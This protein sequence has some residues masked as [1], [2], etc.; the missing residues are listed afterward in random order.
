MFSSLE[1]SRAYAL[2]G[3]A[4]FTMDPAQPRV[5]AVGVV[6]GRIVA[7]GSVADVEAA[8]PADAPRIDVGT[9]MVLPGFTDSHIHFGYLV[10]KWNAV[11]LDNCSSLS[12]ALR[13]VKQYVET[14]SKDDAPWIDGH[15]WAAHQWEEQP[16]AA[17]LD[18]VVAD[19]P[20]AL[21]GKDGHSLWVNSA[22]L[23]VAGIER[24]TPNPPGGVIE[25]HPV[26]GE[27]TGVLYEDAMKLVLDV[28]PPMDVDTLAEAMRASLHRLHALGI[29]A[30]HCP[31]LIM[32]WRA[33]Q[34]LWASGELSVR[35]TFMPPAAKLDELVELGVESGFGDRWLRFGQLKFFADGTLGSRTAAMLAPFEGEPDNIGVTVCGGDELKDL[36][37]RA[38][39]A[40]LSVSIHAIGDRGVREALDAIEA[41]D[42]GALRLPHRI[43]H[44][45]LVDPADMARFSR[46]GVVASMQPAHGAVDRANAL[47]YWGARVAYAS[48][49]RSLADR[50]AVLAFGS[51][52]P[53]GL[54]L[55]DTSFSV[56]VGIYTAMTRRW[57]T[58][59]TAD[60]GGDT[61]EPKRHAVERDAYAPDEVVSLDE[62]LAAYTVGPAI[63]G[64]EAGWR[65]SL[66]IG[67]CADFVVLEENL[68]DVPAD[69]IP[70][71]PVAATIVEGKVVYRGRLR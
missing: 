30:I 2:V 65:G 36:V 35:V 29:T 55:T 43:E 66:R 21:T 14:R 8:L 63:V 16:T 52:A 42:S 20:V 9:R 13:R 28:L 44:A 18:A 12:E 59:L 64:G 15:G 45:Q 48:P 4:I 7:V 50:G 3:D 49:Y 58:D 1:L 25:R 67:H 51:D 39:S 5:R 40:G 6:D 31:E 41:A 34:R 11:D 54:D 24:N 56:L 22:A 32:D 37:G 33:Y 17:A 53:F 62:A 69:E 23:A 10:R 19:R 47:K 60:F 70:N 71:V 68:Y 61:G 57:V 26:T 27:P 46:L 38:T